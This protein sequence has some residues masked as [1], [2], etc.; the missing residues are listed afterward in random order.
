M[1]NCLDDAV[2]D[3]PDASDSDNPQTYASFKFIFRLSGTSTRRKSK[4]I[5]SSLFPFRV[6]S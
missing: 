4:N 2:E 6:G 1:G 5:T 3:D